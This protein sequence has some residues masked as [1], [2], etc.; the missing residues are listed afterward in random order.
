LA[1][2]GNSLLCRLA[3]GEGLIDPAGFTALRLLS[4]AL[5]LLGIFYYQKKTFSGL[6]G[7][8]W[9]AFWLLL[10][11]VGF[12]YAY[13]SL[14]TATG[15]LIL[16]AFVQLTMFLVGLRSGERLR[17]LQWSGLLLAGVGLLCLLLPGL[18]S[19][20]PLG[21]VLMALAGI[22]WGFYSLRGRFVVS[23][24]AAT[25]G[26]FLKTLPLFVPLL[27]W[28]SPM[29]HLSAG[30]V[31]LALLSG[32]LA[33]GCGYVIWYAALPGLSATTAAT[34]QLSVPLLA[35][36][37]GIVLLGEAFSLHLLMAATLILGGV[38]LTLFSRS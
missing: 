24:V 14:T 38:A 31:L 32:A 19:P 25:T 33:S 4:G 11:A 18:T 3:L 13:R 22:A 35:A 20:D 9:S 16:F 7:D 5:I 8:W 29:Q 23:P 26:N 36:L 28:T 17:L 30:G 12:S 1:F 10:Y 2:A 6:A 15:A 27:I 21:A 34:V 37:G